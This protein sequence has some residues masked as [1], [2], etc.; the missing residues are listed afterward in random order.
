MQA[1]LISW[2][3]LFGNVGRKWRCWPE[4]VSWHWE[5][6]WQQQIKVAL[7][8][9]QILS[10]LQWQYVP[11]KKKI[12]LLII[13]TVNITRIMFVFH[14]R[15]ATFSNFTVEDR[16][17]S[18]LLQFYTYV[19]LKYHR[20]RYCH[21]LLFM[22]KRFFFYFGFSVFLKGFLSSPF[23]FLIGEEMF[24]LFNLLVWVQQ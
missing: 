24:H 23:C 2:T 15:N 3:L 18:H 21:F 11:V 12:I 22:A 4:V 10:F 13:L 5:I 9:L 17:S 20:C 1:Y 19:H 7:K 16:N 8:L 14:P 6:K